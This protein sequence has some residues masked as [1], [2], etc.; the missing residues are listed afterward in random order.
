[1]EEIIKEIAENM[2]YVEGGTFMMGADDEDAHAWEQPIH[3][4]TIDSLYI[5]KYLV[6]Q[7]QW[8][9]IMSYNPSKFKGDLQRPVERVSWLDCQYFIK[10]L[11]LKTGKRYRLPTEAE[12]EYVARGGQKSKGYKYAGS[13][14]IDKVAWYWDNADKITHTVGEKQMNELGLYDMSGNVFEWCSDW[15][16]SDYYGNSPLANPQGPD[17]GTYRVARG[18]CRGYSGNF[19]RVVHRYGEESFR[20]AH[21]FGLRLVYS[22]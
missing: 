13:D 18:G 12:W 11:N 19:C 14:D 4:V 16:D 15:Y 8:A 21:N 22:A 2:V 5:S 17:N 7:R 9:A 1:M 6:T 10:R 20:R 3:K